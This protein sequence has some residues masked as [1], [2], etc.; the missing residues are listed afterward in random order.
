MIAFAVYY[1]RETLNLHPSYEICL[2]TDTCVLGTI[3]LLLGIQSGL[4]ERFPFPRMTVF[5][6]WGT[7]WP[8]RLLP[9]TSAV[10]HSPSPAVPAW[11]GA[12]RR[13]GGR[14]QQVWA[15]QGDGGDCR[16][17]WGTRGN[18]LEQSIQRKKEGEGESGKLWG[19]LVPSLPVQGDGGGTGTGWCRGF[20]TWQ[21]SRVISWAANFLKCLL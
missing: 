3:Y 4:Y 17:E 14:W 12:Q 19:G 16:V 8:C 21:K 6:Y 7:A 18:S 9:P 2:R 1:F 13:R 15:G 11:T 20:R 5:C 10:G